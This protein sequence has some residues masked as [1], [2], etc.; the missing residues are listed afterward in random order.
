MSL[1]SS[2]TTT[3]SCRLACLICMICECARVWGSNQDSGVTSSG[4]CE[5][6]GASHN[7]VM[8]RLTNLYTNTAYFCPGQ[9]QVRI[10]SH[11]P[12][13]WMPYQLHKKRFSHCW[14][15]I[16]YFHFSRCYVLFWSNVPWDREADINICF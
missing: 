14:V 12:S 6:P 5:A 7:G 3:I 2:M 13:Y 1:S 11:I 16:F 4:H 15:G 8:S 10:I 9:G